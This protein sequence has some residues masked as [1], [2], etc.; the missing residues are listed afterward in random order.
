MMRNW[1]AWPLVLILSAGLLTAAAGDE[2][3]DGEKKAAPFQGAPGETD[4]T[5]ANASDPGA[6][7]TKTKDPKPGE[8]QWSVKSGEFVFTLSMK[9]GIPDPDQVTEI[10]IDANSIPKTPHPRYGKRVPLEDAKI[11][12]EVTSPSNE[13]VAKV[14][15]HPMPLASGKYGLHVTPFK[16]GVYNLGIRATSADGKPISADVKL[17]VKIWPLPPELQGSGDS[18]KVERKPLKG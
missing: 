14:L 16:E 2:K 10:L 5:S 13:I 7:T 3:K 18:E 11:L 12:V 1:S 9:P 17:P 15:A 8:R 6:S 4:A